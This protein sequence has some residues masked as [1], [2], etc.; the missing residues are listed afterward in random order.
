MSDSSHSSLKRT[1]QQVKNSGRPASR[2]RRTPGNGTARGAGYADGNAAQKAA[3]E[4]EGTEREGDCRN[5]GQTS[6]GH[7]GFPGTDW[8]ET[9]RFEK[10]ISPMTLVKRPPFSVLYERTFSEVPEVRTV[11]R[12]K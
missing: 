7:P 6:D 8:K 10:K 11:R 12:K 2:T 3:N 5:R 9:G 4:D 1:C